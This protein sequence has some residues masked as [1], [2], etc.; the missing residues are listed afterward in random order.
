MFNRGGKVER[1]AWFAFAALEQGTGERRA[2]AYHVG[3]VICLTNVK[4]VYMSELVVGVAFC[5]N[6]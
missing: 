2:V 1:D 3:I 5:F 6:E 4:K